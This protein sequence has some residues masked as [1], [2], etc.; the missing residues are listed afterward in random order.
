M[1]KLLLALGIFGIT[2]VFA[3]DTYLTINNNTSADYTIS[4][5]DSDNFNCQL[6]GQNDSNNCGDDSN[7]LNQQVIKANSSFSVKVST[8]VQGKS[9]M[10]VYLRHSRAGQLLL[11]FGLW[12]YETGS[13]HLPPNDAYGHYS[14]SYNANYANN[15]DGSE[16]CF[17]GDCVW[18]MMLETSNPLVT[19]SMT[20]INKNGSD[21]HYYTA[22]VN[23]NQ[24]PVAS[25]IA[26][27]P[28]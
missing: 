10:L 15:T 12:G 14:L 28:W 25:S 27:L 19:T 23:V 1:K 6:E 9:S 22:T 16:T 20:F 18:G 26:R 13:N 17:D 5:M 7:S 24:S 2:H 3:I 11:G 4:V 8:P 21:D